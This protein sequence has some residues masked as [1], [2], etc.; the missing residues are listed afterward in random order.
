MAMKENKKV[1]HEESSA[2]ADM[3]LGLS[4]GKRR[5]DDPSEAPEEEGSATQ[6][7]SNRKLVNE[8]RTDESGAPDDE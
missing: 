2:D 7:D 4:T 6:I 5:G 3:G 1:E 8:H